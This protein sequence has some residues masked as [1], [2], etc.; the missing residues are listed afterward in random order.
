M[1]TIILGFG[2]LAGAFLLVVCC[3][4]FGIVTGSFACTSIL[5]K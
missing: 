5:E 2:T 3:I 4:F 1:Y